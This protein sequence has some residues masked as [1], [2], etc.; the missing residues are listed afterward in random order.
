MEKK[1][2]STRMSEKDGSSPRR[3]ERRNSADR[4]ADNR[5]AHARFEPGAG[6]RSDRRQSDRRT[7]ED[8]D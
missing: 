4:R 3:D 5:R 1:R 6:A 2:K 8:K 7:R